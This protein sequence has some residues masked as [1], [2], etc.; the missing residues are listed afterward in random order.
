[1]AGAQDAFAWQ[2]G[3]WDRISPLYLREIDARFA[4]V[5][6]NVIERANL[7]LGQRVLDL[8][9]G[10][11]SVALAAALLVG[12]SGRVVGID[13]S[14][15]MLEVANARIKQAGLDNAELREGRAEQIPAAAAEFDA[16]IASL[17]LMYAIDRAAAAREIARVL[18][19]GGR[20]VAAV[21]AAPEH[22]DIVRFQQ[23]AGS[24]APPPA[25][26]VGP[27]ALANATEFL[28]QLSSAGIDAHVETE[29][30][31]FDFGSFEAAW[32]VLAAV[33]TAGL[34]PERVSEAQAAVKSA[35]WPHKGPRHFRNLTQ[36]VI[37]VRR[38]SG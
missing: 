3:I 4:A 12:P 16:V 31:G 34:A 8:G 38:S 21:W 35:M 17:S 28:D 23:I 15:Q 29:L 24:F 7:K 5:V 33:T 25:P 20:F 36:F 26:G 27:G 32:E 11:G 6:R 30:L 14:Q 10:T 13:I 18:S 19:P 1:M 9:T 37:G 2:I 22:C